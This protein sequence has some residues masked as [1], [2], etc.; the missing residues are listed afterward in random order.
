[1]LDPEDRTVLL[2]AL[3]PPDGYVFD[4]GIGTTYTLDLIS[5]L[6]VPLAFTLF[7]WEDAQGQPTSN[8]VLLMEALR[9]HIRRLTIFCQAG[10]IGVPK[11]ANPLLGFLEE[12]VVEVST[13]QPG[14]I[15]HPKI[16]ALRYLNEATDEV[17]YRLLCLSRNLTNDRCWDLSLLLEGPLVERTRAFSK[18]HPLGDFFQSLPQLA[19]R[20]IPQSSRDRAQRIADELR[21]VDFASELPDQFESVAFHPIGIDGYRRSPLPKEWDRGL[22][23]SPFIDEEQARVLSEEGGAGILVSRPE[24][25]DKLPQETLTSFTEVVILSPGAEGELE[26]HEVDDDLIEVDRPRGLHAKLYVFDWGSRTQ[27]FVGSANATNAAFKQN[28]EFLVELVGKRRKIGSDELLYDQNGPAGLGTILTQ[29]QSPE[30]PVREDPVERRLEEILDAGRSIMA[31]AGWSFAAER[32]DEGLWSLA[33]KRSDDSPLRF[34]ENVRIKAWPITLPEGSSAQAITP[35][36]LSI[37]FGEVGTSTLTSFLACEAEATVD[38]KTA[39]ARFVL[40]L[41]LEGAPSNRREAILRLILDD[42]HKVVRFLQFL[43]E[44]GSGEPVEHGSSIGGI[45]GGSN[46]SGPEGFV[47]LESLLRALANNP[48]RLDQVD[49]VLR[50]L[51][52]E[53][54][55]RTKLPEGLL[56]VWP[57]IWAARGMIRT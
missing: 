16:W 21:R 39:N 22:F 53:G 2:E 23:I 43:L 27:V 4:Q 54:P 18:N 49:S 40:N 45:G 8:P 28:I 48:S 34:P 56:E 24:E 19:L 51:T 7:E 33:L 31:C 46:G 38:T 42:P 47:L 57:A 29:Y 20:Q 10:R 30:K 13:G 9:R 26:P 6:S 55:D 11:P 32:S 17:R 44:D 15:F 3:A 52:A 14:G 36:T 50:D 37:R 12:S 5:L 1:M 35:E 25:L 41:P